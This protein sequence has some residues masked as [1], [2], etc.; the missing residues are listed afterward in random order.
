LQLYNK[1]IDNVNDGF[2]DEDIASD[3]GYAGLYTTYQTSS[4]FS[5]F[6]YF[7]PLPIDSNRLLSTKTIKNKVDLYIFGCFSSF[8]Y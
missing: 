1:I 7:E 8:S 5:L 2:S 3:P 4:L 6:L